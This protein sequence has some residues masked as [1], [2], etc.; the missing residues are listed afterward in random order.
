MAYQLGFQL[1]SICELQAQREHLE[2]QL[3]VVTAERDALKAEKAGA[4]G[5]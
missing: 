5:T 3:V 4:S 1:L 2:Q